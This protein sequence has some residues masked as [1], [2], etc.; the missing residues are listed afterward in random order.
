MKI[1]ELKHISPYLPYGL[2]I[3]NKSLKGH[4]LKTYF[5]E[6]DNHNDCGITNVIYGA[7]Q[8]PILRPLSD[9][10]KEIE[11]NGEKLVP[12]IEI[13]KAVSLFDLSQCKF[14]YG[15]EENGEIYNDEYWINS[16]KSESEILVDSLMFDENIFTYAMHDEKYKP[17]EPQHEAF[18]LL[19]KFHFDWRYSLIQKGLAID[20]NTLNK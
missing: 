10:T 3:A 11:V 5:M 9:L 20:I 15:I 18:S 8:I 12:I 13:L 1:L 19:D 4:I 2:R 14:E 6:E 17:A 16:L 7:N